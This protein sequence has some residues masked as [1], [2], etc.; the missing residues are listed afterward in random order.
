MLLGWPTGV[1]A[2]RKPLTVS[3]CVFLSL[4]LPTIIPTSVDPA[5]SILLSSLTSTQ[6]ESAGLSQAQRA[7]KD[8]WFKTLSWRTFLQHVLNPFPFLCL[9]ALSIFLEASPLIRP[10]LLDIHQHPENDGDFLSICTLLCLYLC[11]TKSVALFLRSFSE[12]PYLCVH[13][14][15]ALS[16]LYHAHRLDKCGSVVKQL[17][18]APERAKINH[19]FPSLS[20]AISLR[21]RLCSSLL[22]LQSFRSSVCN[23]LLIIILFWMPFNTSFLFQY[24]AFD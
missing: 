16:S 1:R 13:V 4:P 14:S 9:L 22:L 12:T 6:G 8:M 5:F 2:W 20:S 23:V 18:E 24:V 11:F 15:L 10:R 7:T 3:K 19:F 21:L 17:P